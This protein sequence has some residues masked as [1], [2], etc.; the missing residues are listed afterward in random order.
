MITIL[1][2]I[3][4]HFCKVKIKFRCQLTSFAI[5]RLSPFK[6]MPVIRVRQA[7]KVI[8]RSLQQINGN[9][10]TPEVQIPTRKGL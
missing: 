2:L 4:L 1:L 6:L 10:N 3:A 5:F 8:Q 9:L 7:N